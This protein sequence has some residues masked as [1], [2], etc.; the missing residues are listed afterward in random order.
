MT[1][2]SCF[3][4]HI[5]YSTVLFRFQ[6]G[7]ARIELPVAVVAGAVAEAAGAV[8]LAALMYRLDFVPWWYL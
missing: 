2:T 1:L 7:L 8:V 3:S 4:A 6:S 5:L